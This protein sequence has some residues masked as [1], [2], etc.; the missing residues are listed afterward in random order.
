MQLAPGELVLLDGLV[1]LH[2]SLLPQVL[3]LVLVLTLNVVVDLLVLQQSH[4]LKE[5]VGGFLQLTPLGGVF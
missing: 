3:E 1:N 5:R 4:V 2:C